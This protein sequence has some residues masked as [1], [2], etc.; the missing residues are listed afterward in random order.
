MRL[1]AG[2]REFADVMAR[3]AAGDAN[4]SIRQFRMGCQ[5]IHQARRGA[6]VVPARVARSVALFPIILVSHFMV[7]RNMKRDA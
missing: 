6:A 4:G 5:K 3:A 7:E 1:K 2:A